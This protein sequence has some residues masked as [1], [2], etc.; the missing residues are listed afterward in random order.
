MSRCRGATPKQHKPL[1]TMRS[2]T[3]V[4]DEDW[5]VIERYSSPG[6]DTRRRWIVDGLLAAVGGGDAA[7][8]SSPTGSFKRQARTKRGLRRHVLYA[9]C[10]VIAGLVALPPNGAFAEEPPLSVPKGG[11]L[12]GAN[13][14]LN[15]N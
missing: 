6:K 1:K 9:L 13:G 3:A 12:G 7:R 14:A 2:Q 15:F 4:I 11:P 5:R 8:W 10:A